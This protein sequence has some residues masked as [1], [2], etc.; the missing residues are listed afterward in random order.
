VKPAPK[1]TATA[2]S[3]AF[4]AAVLRNRADYESSLRGRV[5]EELE[6]EAMNA[7]SVGTDVAALRR[8][9][10][11]QKSAFEAQAMQLQALKQTV[12]TFERASGL[13]LASWN[14][15]EL[16]A[17]VKL[18]ESFN[19]GQLS[20]LADQFERIAKLARKA[21]GE[22]AQLQLSLGEASS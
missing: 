16:G 3:P 10:E 14:A 17:A 7:E 15:Q 8:V 22:L 4:V 11:S 5:K 13:H 6:R 12:E 1:R 20:N 9:V 19:A 21:H 18:A 2:L